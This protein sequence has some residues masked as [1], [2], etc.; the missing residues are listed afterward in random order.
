MSRL[1]GGCGQ[2]VAAADAFC[3]FCGA[4]VEQVGETTEP[5]GFGCAACGAQMGNG[6]RFCT[7]C[8]ASR[9][10]ETTSSEA[11]AT[12][13]KTDRAPQVGEVGAGSSPSASGAPRTPMPDRA[14]QP[15]VHRRPPRRRSWWTSVMVM[16]GVGI[17]T[18][19]A[20]VGAYLVV[21][22]FAD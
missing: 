22:Y 11:E 17:A 12:W 2:G 1:C 9:S 7:A 4:R 3:T 21:T 10:A 16:I 8:G 6:D 18:T 15:S 5:G 14:Y 20:F 19:A 13:L